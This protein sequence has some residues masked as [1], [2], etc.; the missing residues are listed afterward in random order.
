VPGVPLDQG[1]TGLRNQR[2]A[3]L[4]LPAVSAR[5]G[6]PIGSDAFGETLS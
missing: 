5:L 1:R 6:H 2:G 4:P 3:V